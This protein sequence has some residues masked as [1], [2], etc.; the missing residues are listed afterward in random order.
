MGTG[1][2]RTYTNMKQKQIKSQRQTCSHRPSP[3]PL[4]LKP[5]C[6]SRNMQSVGGPDES[7]TFS[8]SSSSAKR[9]SN[10]LRSWC[11]PNVWRGSVWGGGRRRDVKKKEHKSWVKTSEEVVCLSGREDNKTKWKRWQWWGRGSG[12]KKKHPA[13]TAETRY[14]PL[15]LQQGRAVAEALLSLQETKKCLHHPQN[16]TESRVLCSAPHLCGFIQVQPGLTDDPLSVLQLG[17]ELA[18]FSGQLLK[19]LT[20]TENKIIH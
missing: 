8:S 20:Q 1:A 4:K 2:G 10:T 3:G 16:D 17:L 5:S 18:V 11:Q 14:L 7:L 15:Q 6:P 12:T 13:P 9:R 19:Q